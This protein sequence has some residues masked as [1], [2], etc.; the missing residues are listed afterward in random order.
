MTDFIQIKTEDNIQVKIRKEIRLMSELFHDLIS[1]YDISKESNE[2][3][4]NIYSK[5]L[6]LLIDFCEKCN[7]KPIEL[8]KPFWKH[9]VTYQLSTLNE[10]LNA[11]YNELSL[12][13]IL[14]YLKICDYYSVP[15][16]EEVIYL[17]LYSILSSDK[18][19]IDDFFQLKNKD[20]FQM[21]T[22]I[23]ESLRMKYH[24]YLT[25][26][27][28]EEMTDEELNEYCEKFY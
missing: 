27:T 24:K 2:V 26:K 3:M 5:D 18:Q 6:H 10:A 11:F 23:E 25:I 4:S 21:N 13:K 7:Y 1:N 9:T 19:T 16:L 28:I 8:S 15:S 20:L 17:K 14:E 12:K 22:D